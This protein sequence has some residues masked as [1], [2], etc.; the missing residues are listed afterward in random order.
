MVGNL[1]TR[2]WKS[3]LSELLWSHILH[4]WYTHVSSNLAYCCFPL[5]SK[6]TLLLMLCMY[7]G[8]HWMLENPLGSLVPCG[9]ISIECVF[10]DG[11][12]IC[13]CSW[14]SHMW[15]VVRWTDMTAYVYSLPDGLS[16]KCIHLWGCLELLP[17]SP[18]SS[19]ATMDLWCTCKGHCW[20]DLSF[21]EIKY[22]WI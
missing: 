17:K 4:P 18:Q 6:V 14:V 3:D 2:Y 8:A 1:L 11:F 20:C 7:R 5:F 13:L 19:L 21:L 16:S 15:M 9:N 12:P 10:I 22:A